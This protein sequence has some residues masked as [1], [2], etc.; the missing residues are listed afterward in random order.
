VNRNNNNYK[1]FDSNIGI[2]LDIEPRINETEI[3]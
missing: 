2:S 3:A 1:Q